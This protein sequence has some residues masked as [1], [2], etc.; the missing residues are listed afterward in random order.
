LGKAGVLRYYSQ[1]YDHPERVSPQLQGIPKGRAAGM[2]G[3]I[4]NL[5]DKRRWLVLK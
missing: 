5:P 3:E 1:W 4:G 2:E